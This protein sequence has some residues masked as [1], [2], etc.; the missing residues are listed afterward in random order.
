MKHIFL[1]IALLFVFSPINTYAQ[2]ETKLH[3]IDQVKSQE[4]KEQNS[5]IE[6]L[7]TG[8]NRGFS[9]SAFMG[10]LLFIL[11]MIFIFRKFNEVKK[12]RD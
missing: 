8:S 12:N 10:S 1:I 6:S 7:E 5:K 11:T 4:M 3:S 2:N 9:I